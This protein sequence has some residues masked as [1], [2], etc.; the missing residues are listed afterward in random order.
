MDA[1][2]R[3][4]TQDGQEL[5]PRNLDIFS[6]LVRSGV[7]QPQ[8]QVFDALTGEW[9]TASHH[10]MVQ[11]LLDPLVVDPT[12]EPLERRVAGREEAPVDEAGEGDAGLTLELVEE[13]SPEE[14]AQAFIARMDEERRSDPD[15]PALSHELAMVDGAAPAVVEPTVDESSEAASQAAAVEPVQPARRDAPPEP[16]V[17]R[18]VEE[19]RPRAPRPG[20]PK[21]RQRGWVNAGILGSAVLALSLSVLLPPGSSD[22]PLAEGFAQAEEGRSS[23]R[24]VPRNEEEARSMA[25]ATFLDGVEALREEMG[26]GEVP[27][28]WL[29]G[30]YLADPGAY[31]EVRRYWE[32]QL[33]F[34]D[35][36][37][38][39]EVTL[40]RGAYLTAANAAGLSGPVRSLR[41]AAAQ[42]DFA[43]SWGRR[44]ALYERVEELARSALALDDLVLRMTGRVTYE[45]IAGRRVSADPV[46]EAAGADPEAQARLEAALDRVLRALAQPDGSSRDRATV[47]TWLVDGL[48]R[49]EGAK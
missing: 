21:Y 5:T 45:P 10:P 44:D 29:E 42:E 1:R 33:A 35:A 15:V 4:R 13:S 31:P 38:A 24:L 6:D 23:A 12:A 46:I 28:I 16:W 32:R 40:Y 34:L 9:A 14:E 37:R 17:P 49:V 3:I 19:E 41:L 2:F 39:A 30:S 36:V 7:V 27:G 20:K 8:D 43:A 18:V 47:P 22:T 26:V 25:L 48:R 11:L